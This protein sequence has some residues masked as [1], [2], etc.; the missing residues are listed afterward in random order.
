MTDH[1]DLAEN[2]LRA[3]EARKWIACLICARYIGERINGFAQELADRM[4]YNDVSR[5]SDLADAGRARK[6]LRMKAKDVYRFRISVFT[7]CWKVIQQGNDPHLVKLALLDM[8]EEWHR[9]KMKDVTDALAGMFDM[10]PKEIT[11]QSWLKTL[12]RMVSWGEQKLDHEDK[13]AW[14]A[15]TKIQREILRRYRK[16]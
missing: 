7:Y 16:D 1:L 12:D 14:F 11:A 10:P 3:G 5:I 6:A 8:L 15:S 4:G 2:A 9:P 13:T